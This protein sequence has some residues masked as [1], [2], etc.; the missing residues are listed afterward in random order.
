MLILQHEPSHGNEGKSLTACWTSLFVSSSD[1]YMDLF[2]I[3]YLSDSAQITTNTETAIM[4][5]HCYLILMLM[6]FTNPD[7]AS[8]HGSAAKIFTFWKS[9]GLRF[10]RFYYRCKLRTVFKLWSLGFHSCES[11]PEER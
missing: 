6:S 1:C 5:T 10:L 8:Y 9:E 7:R 11:C 2:L 3:Q 4:S